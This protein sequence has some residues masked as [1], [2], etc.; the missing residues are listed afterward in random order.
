MSNVVLVWDRFVR[1]FHWSIVVLFTLAYY[2]SSSGDDDIHA[3]AGY[4][5]TVLLFLRIVWGLLST[6]YARFTQFLYPFQEIWQHGSQI[7]CNNPR[8][9]LGHSPMGSVM[10]FVLLLLILL[11]LLSGLISQGWGEYEGPLWF[12]GLMPS[13]E[14]GHI[15]KYMHARLPDIL[16]VIIVLHVAG[17]LLAC[18]QHQENLVRSM[19]TGCKNKK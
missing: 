11:L 1:L 10:V 5:M 7:C 16:I 4:L 14:V 15:T 3:I 6:G 2:T 9:Y 18:Y 8:H 19:F 17:V 13:D 12:M